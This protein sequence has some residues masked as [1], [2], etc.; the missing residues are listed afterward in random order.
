MITQSV[1]ARSE[2]KKG[3]RAGCQMQNNGQVGYIM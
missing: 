1:G 2:V 3:A